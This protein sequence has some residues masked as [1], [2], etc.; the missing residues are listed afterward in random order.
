MTVV[1]SVC[2]ILQDETLKHYVCQEKVPVCKLEVKTAFDLLTKEEKLYAHHFAKACWAGAP[3]VLNQVSREAPKIFSFLQ[4]LFGDGGLQNLKQ[5]ASVRKEVLDQVLVYAAMFFG[6][7]GN[8]TSFG[9]SKFIPRC[10]A[11]EFEELVRTANNPTA[12]Q[13]W[14]EV[15]A[16]MYS[17]EKRELDFGNSSYYSDDVTK[18]EA[19]KIQEFMNKEN[20]SAFNTRLFKQGNNHFVLRLASAK[21]KAPIEHEYEGLKITITYGDHAPYMKRIC[22]NLEKCLP[23]A[24]EVQAAMIRKYI[25][26]FD[27][28]NIEDH[29]EAQKLWIKDKGPAVETNIGFIE[30]YRDPLRVRGEFEGFVAVV[31]KEMSKKFG[32]LV[33]SAQ[34][35][36]RELPWNKHSTPDQPFEIETFSK[37]DFTALEILAFAVSGLPAGINI[38]NYEDIREHIGFKNVSLSNVLSAVSPMEVITMLHENDIKLFKELRGRAFEVQVGL[39]ELLGHGSGKTIVADSNGR[40]PLD[41]SQVV[42]P[43]T[44]KNDITT[45]YKHGETFNA[46]F[47]EISN[48]YEE[49]R[50]EAVGIYLSTF[51]KV[52]DI[53]G[54][55]GQMAEDILYI[56]WLSMVRAGLLGLEFYNPES[57][58]WLQAHMRARYCILQVLLE[59]GENFV[60]IIEEKDNCYITLDRSKIKTVGMKAMDRFLLQLGVYKST[61]NLKDGI[62][63][64][65]RYTTVNDRFLR[66]R[67]IVLEKKQPRKVFVQP[68]TVCNQQDV[69]LNEFEPSYEGMVDCFTK[70]VQL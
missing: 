48:S 16:D 26:H 12:L 42:N 33:N 17:L 45:Y 8:Y 36:L 5:N 44:G 64:Y 43:I 9:D 39:H 35:L 38:P 34:E 50:A 19:Q 11:S 60:Q 37:P 57:G 63:M 54:H 6:N 14:N 1:P 31:N 3:I 20:I 22:E 28:G 65:Q 29:K 51:D 47:G 58:K 59:A 41:L 46:M 25:D 15:K 62:E 7:M 4:T 13:L 67:K 49:C 27:G 61:C 69:E 24:N 40:L 23:Y 2:S 21:S 10:E 66:I 56:N 70:L 18:N 68:L 53:F 52:L 32:T 30:S 55:R